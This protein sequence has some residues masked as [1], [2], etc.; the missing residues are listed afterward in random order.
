MPSYG[1]NA[2]TDGDGRYKWRDNRG[3]TSALQPLLLL[4]V[5]SYTTYATTAVCQPQLTGLIQPA[6]KSSLTV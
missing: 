5:C 4:Q 1:W 2:A 6:N 3:A